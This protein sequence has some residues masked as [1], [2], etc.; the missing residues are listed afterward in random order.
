[1]N[2]L[3]TAVEGED[4]SATETEEVSGG[5]SSTTISCLTNDAHRVFESG[6]RSRLSRT[7]SPFLLSPSKAIDVGASDASDEEDEE[8]G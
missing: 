6:N 4:G 2:F 8:K 1:M 5:K 7:D 3:P